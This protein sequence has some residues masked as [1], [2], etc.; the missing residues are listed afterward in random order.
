MLGELLAVFIAG[1]MPVSE[2]RGAIP[3]ALLLFERAEHKVLGVLV[4]IIGNLL[5]SPVLLLALG[6][7]EGWLLRQDGALRRLKAI[8]LGR[9]ESTRRRAQPMVKRYGY[10][11]L[12]LF[13]ATPL[14]ITGAWTGTLVAHVLGMKYWKSVAS[15]ELGVLL[16]SLIVGLLS[17]VG[18]MPFLP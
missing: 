8:Y 3:L 9:V 1:L 5:V 14:P 17:A 15:I 7:A 2:V 10:L 12:V 13:V 16:A 18:L 4:G 6:S 11:G